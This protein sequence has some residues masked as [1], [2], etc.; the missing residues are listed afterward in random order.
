M[1]FGDRNGFHFGL[2]FGDSSSGSR[3][4]IEYWLF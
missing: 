2:H 3:W 1:M 4:G